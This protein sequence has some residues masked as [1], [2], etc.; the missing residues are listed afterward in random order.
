MLRAIAFLSACPKAFSARI[1]LQRLLE[2]SGA[3]KANLLTR[4][5]VFGRLL[6]MLLHNF[7]AP[8]KNIYVHIIGDELTFLEMALLIETTGYFTY[9]VLSGYHP[10]RSP[11]TR[12]RQHWT[13]HATLLTS[14]TGWI[15][16]F[17]NQVHSYQVIIAIIVAA[18]AKGRSAS[19]PQ[20]LQYICPRSILVEKRK[21]LL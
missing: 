15:R 1:V 9:S 10:S 21:C 6:E 20:M 7:D 12:Q 17:T 13:L 4:G 8:L 11:E 3:Q 16:G 5:V 18:L 2:L 14:E 19:C